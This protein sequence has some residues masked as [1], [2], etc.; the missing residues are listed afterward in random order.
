MSLLFSLIIPVYKVEDYIEKCIRSCFKQSNI[1]S[2]EYEI[3]VVDDASPDKSIDI[4]L[5]VAL[6][7]PKHNL[8]IIH[9]EN[10]GLSAARNTGLVNAKGK[11][12]WFIDSDDWIATDALFKLKNKLRKVNNVD[13][14]SFAHRVEYSD[15]HFSDICN[16]PDYEGDGYKFLE[17]NNFLSACSRIYQRDFLFYHN[18]FFYEGYLWEDAQFNIRALGIC[19]KHYYYHAYLYFYLRRNNSIT[20]TGISDKMEMSRFHLIDTVLEFFSN[21]SLTSYQR[22]IL[23][24]K[25]GNILFAAIVGIRELK[26]S[27]AIDYKKYFLK[28]RKKYLSILF[29]SG[30][31]KF[32]F[33]GVMLN[34]SFQITS[35]CL[36][37]YMNKILIK[38][39]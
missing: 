4:V 29:N 26:N 24:Q 32:H 10:G 21:L 20:T 18:L 13:I 11:Y 5:R 39:R 14:L 17:K 2:D 1:L 37:L 22:Q 8:H 16:Q 38:N 12:V 9:R 30:K 23:N 34:V 28:E 31:I 6:E 27:T 7:Y 25:L 36:F 19:K 3:I 33:I 35:Y 15:G